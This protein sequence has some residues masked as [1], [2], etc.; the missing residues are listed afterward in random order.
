MA[1]ILFC[2][3]LEKAKT[4][5]IQNRWYNKVYSCVI[6]NSKGRLHHSCEALPLRYFSYSSKNS[7][8]RRR[9]IERIFRPL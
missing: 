6:S 2:F 9:S 3:I 4:L 8:F 1:Y 7:I 5:I